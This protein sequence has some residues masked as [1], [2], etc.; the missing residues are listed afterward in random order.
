MFAALGAG[1]IAKTVGAL[2][3]SVLK[4]I[5]AHYQNKD[6]QWGRV[7]A[8]ALTTQAEIEAANADARVRMVQSRMG[9][10]LLFLIVAPP[11]AY[12]GSVF[13]VTLLYD[14]TG[15]K[16]TISALPPGWKELGT[17]IVM[18]FIGGRGVVAAAGVAAKTWF[19]R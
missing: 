18:V 5:L 12:I 10:F 3:S 11:A 13:L 16:L 9:A 8:S 17:N 15:W 14:V 2:G 7:L 4:P 1:L 6:T 19:K